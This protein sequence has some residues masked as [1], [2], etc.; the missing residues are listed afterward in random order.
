MDNPTILLVFIDLLSIVLS[1]QIPGADE[2]LNYDI[3]ICKAKYLVQSFYSDF[4][5]EACR[6]WRI[7]P[8]CKTEE[9]E[10]TPLDNGLMRVSM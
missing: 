6:V 2:I 10:Y 9:A 4:K 1:L 5:L 3:F 7:L 8:Y